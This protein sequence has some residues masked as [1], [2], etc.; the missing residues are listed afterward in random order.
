MYFDLQKKEEENGPINDVENVDKIRSKFNNIKSR[1]SVVSCIIDFSDKV[2]SFNIFIRTTFV[3][4]SLTALHTT[5][6]KLRC[7]QCKNATE[8]K[9][10]NFHW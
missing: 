1:Q 10:F 2:L 6:N 4:R 7:T 9:N 3:Q 8:K 5:N